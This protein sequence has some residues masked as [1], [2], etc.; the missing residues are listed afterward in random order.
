M[1]D[2]SHALLVYIGNFDVLVGADGSNSF[3]RRYCNIQM[4]SEGLEYACGVAYNIPK[5]VAPADEPLH[6]ALNCILT[7]SQTRYLVNSSNSR[8]GYL[9]IRLIQSEYDEL[10]ERLLTFQSR[11]EAIDL[12]DYDKCPQSPVWSIIRQGLDFFRIAP[13]FVFRV[14]PIEINVRHA[15]I[16]VREMRYEVEEPST[17][18]D[19]KPKKHQYKTALAFLVGDAALNVHFWP[20]RGMNSGMKGAMAL[21][22]NIVRSCLMKDAPYTIQPRKPLRFLDFLDYEGFMARLRAR[23]QQGRSLRV[24][25]DPIDKSVEASYSYAHLNHCYIK[26]THKL[27]EKLK[28]IRQRL[29]ERPEWPHQSRP[30]TDDELNSSVQS[31]LVF[32][33]GTAV[34]GQSMANS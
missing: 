16:V 31:C 5:E 30:V 33:S 32:G 15:S 13:K 27:K 12:M 14:V 9:N 28:D 20:G 3:V 21:A 23:E 17:E 8:R 29:Q 10:R 34:A 11:N 7:V 22:R 19:K 24:L 25:I 6:Q 1:K 18:V 4:I 2:Y 26:Y